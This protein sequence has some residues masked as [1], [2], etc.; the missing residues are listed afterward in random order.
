MA[1]PELPLTLGWGKKKK[2][3]KKK[4]LTG[5][6]SKVSKHLTGDKKSIN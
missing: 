2:K 4:L 6:D 5:K 3:K 1:F